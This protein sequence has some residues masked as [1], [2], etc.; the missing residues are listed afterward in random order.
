MTT[1]IRLRRMGSNKRPF[2]RVVVADQRSPRDG[3]FIENIGKYHPLDDPSVIEID[4]SRALH[5]LRVGA[6]PS[7]QVRNLMKKVGI[8]E[9]FVKERPSAD[10]GP[11]K[12]RTSKPK[13]SKKA[14]QKA[15]ASAS[16]PEPADREAPVEE[17]APEVSELAVVEADA[18][19]AVEAVAE[20]D[21]AEAVEAVADVP[22]DESPAEAAP[23]EEA[24]SADTEEPPEAGTSDTEDA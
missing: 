21:A 5:W 10:S 19:E 8:W 4:Q 13:L 12:E 1:R 15:E 7:D 11:A 18:A 16:G 9:E 2:F 24:A 14:K 23:A 17:P 22:A 3:R 6:Q 20:A